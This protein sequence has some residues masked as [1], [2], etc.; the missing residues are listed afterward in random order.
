MPSLTVL[1]VCCVEKFSILIL[2]NGKS[3]QRKTQFVASLITLFISVI[4]SHKSNEICYM[5]L[6]VFLN[7]YCNIISFNLG[8]FSLRNYELMTGKAPCVLDR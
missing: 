6:R 7:N 5:A 3:T 1:I 8:R 4:Y 2:L